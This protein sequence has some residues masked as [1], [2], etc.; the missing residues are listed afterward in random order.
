MTKKST[1]ITIAV[2]IAIVAFGGGWAYGKNS[3][4]TSSTASNT[5]AQFRNFSGANSAG[6]RTFGSRSGAG[7][8]IGTVVSMDASSISIALPV[9]TSTSATTGSQ[10]VLYSPSTSITKTV[11]GSASDLSVGESV[12]VQGTPNSDGSL[13]ANSIQVRPTAGR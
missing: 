12:V 13:T 11:V 3:V 5:N 7:A 4:G 6:T 1:Q 8:V 10:V 9:S 2:I